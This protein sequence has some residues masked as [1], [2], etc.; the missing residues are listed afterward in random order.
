MLIPAD[1]EQH[2]SLARVVLG[3]LADAGMSSLTYNAV[4]AQSGIGTSSLQRIWASRVEAVTDALAEVYGEHP[5]PDTG[6]LRADLRT[7]VGQLANTL[8]EPRARQV[9]GALVAEAATDPALSSELRERVLHPRRAELGRRLA[10]DQEQINAPVDAAV[11]QLVG[12]I[13]HRALLL[14]LPVD[15]ALLDAIVDGLTG[16]AA[17]HRPGLT[18]RAVVAVSVGWDARHPGNARGTPM[19]ADNAVSMYDR[20]RTARKLLGVP[21][22]LAAVVLLSSCYA[23]SVPTP[24]GAGPLRYRDQVFSSYD[25]SSN[26]S[27]GTAPD[28]N[29][30]PVNLILD[31]YTPTG[32]TATGRPAI[33][34]VHGGGFIGGTKTSGPAV[35][36]AQSFAKRGYVTVSINYRLLANPGCGGGGERGDVQ[37]HQRGG[38][39]HR[40]R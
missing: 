33:V 25:L 34:F 18:R 7:Y 38:R 31:L 19:T 4:S 35:T 22:V 30:N 36:M 10:R 29:G 20:A 28:R 5:V 8:A 32:D 3:L 37:L 23:D 40:R 2:R 26:V 14:D 12:P 17:P 11:D 13:Y 24:G 9:L 39:R 1:P 16:E 21:L 15:D 27:Y 6:D